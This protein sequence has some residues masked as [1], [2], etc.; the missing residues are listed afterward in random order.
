MARFKRMI[1]MLRQSNPVYPCHYESRCTLSDGRAVMIRPIWHTDSK[2]LVELFAKLSPDSRYR[3]FL[4]PLG[5]LPDDLLFRLTHI[6]Y[7]KNFALVAVTGE[8]YN[9]AIIAVAR[10]CTDPCEKQT[11]FAIVVH[12]DWQGGGQTQLVQFSHTESDAELKAVTVDLTA[13]RYFHHGRNSDIGMTLGLVYQRFDYDIIGYD[14]WQ[15]DDF[16]IYYHISC[17]H[18]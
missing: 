3:R 16:A 8:A 6:D 5:T 2:R 13:T 4:V 7:R 1:I 11:D 10:Y 12:D 14:G 18:C 15:T 9:G 17:Q